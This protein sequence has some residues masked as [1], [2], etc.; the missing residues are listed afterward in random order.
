MRG[1]EGDGWGWKWRRSERRRMKREFGEATEY[2][3]IRQPQTEKKNRAEATY[4]VKRA[5]FV[6]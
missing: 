5:S 2:I 3:N 4:K 6:Q 1:G